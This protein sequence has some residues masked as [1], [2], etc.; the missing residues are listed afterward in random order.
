MY[1]YIHLY[2]F[3]SKMMELNLY[4]NISKE[5]KYIIIAEFFV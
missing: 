3:I 5:L 2:T 1:A 4:L